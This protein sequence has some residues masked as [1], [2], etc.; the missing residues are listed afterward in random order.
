MNTSDTLEPVDDI[1][2]ITHYP[3]QYAREATVILRRLAYLKLMTQNCPYSQ[4]EAFED[5]RDFEDFLHHLCNSKG[6]DIADFVNVPAA[7]R[8]DE[9]AND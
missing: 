1:N 7:Y 5:V 3:V 9:G 6:R 4:L 8:G 2:L